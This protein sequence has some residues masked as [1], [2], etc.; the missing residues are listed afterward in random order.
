MGRGKSYHPEQIS[1]LFFQYSRNSPL[2]LQPTHNKQHVAEPL[3]CRMPR[4]FRRY[5]SLDGLL[6]LHLDVRLDLLQQLR[7]SAV[8][9]KHNDA[10]VAMN[11]PRPPA[12]ECSQPRSRTSAIWMFR[13]RASCVR[14]RSGGKTWPF[15]YFRKL[16]PPRGSSLASSVVATRDRVN[17]GPPATRRR[18]AARSNR[19]WRVH[20]QAPLPVS[21]EPINRACPASGQAGRL[22]F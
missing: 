19:Q 16:H 6:R 20:G 18:S 17:H 15:D 7:P 22:F 10:P 3:P 9:A 14:R 21:G 2:P 5:P 11:S 4:L 1:P 8:P 12:R 13:R